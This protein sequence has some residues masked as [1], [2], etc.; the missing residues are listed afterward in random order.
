MAA[1][2]FASLVGVSRH[3]LYLWKK[4]F[5]EQGPA[6]LM[7]QPRGAK[8]GSRVP[9]LT[10]RAILL[11]KEAHPD[12]G[13]QRISDMLL[14]GP[15]LPVCASAV[16]K[17]LH[18]AGYQFE[19][20]ATRPHPDK[21]RFFERA[22]PNQLWQTD[23]FTFVLKRQNRRV[24]LVAFMDDH[25]RFITCFGL[26]G[27]ASTA[28]VIE[29]LR[30]EIASHGTPEEVLTDNGPQYVTWRGKSQFAKEVEK[31]GIR[32]IVAAPR[33][34]RTLGKIERFW[35][36]LWRECVE[37]AVFLDLD[38]AR[39]R[40]GLFIDGYNFSRPHSGIGGL[41]PADRYFRATPE[42]MRTLK[43]R[44]AANALELARNG[45][46]REPFYVTGQ[47]GGQAFSLHAEGERVFLLKE[48]GQRQE[49]DLGA[50]P[51]LSSA[52]EQLPTPVCPDGSLRGDVMGE[53]PLPG[54]AVWEAGEAEASP[55]SQKGAGS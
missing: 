54:Q 55:V 25:S 52:A 49:V 45:V 23:L 50:Q 35:G 40:I 41:V 31:R 18:E 27:S 15:A 4:L 48:G 37:G 42:V 47:V 51:T 22:S 33:K 9:E 6:G 19:E 34:P 13:C 29:V 46:P 10:R 8:P 21:P 39:T 20:V 26:Y 44:V 7:E 16:S 1:G 17:V 43:A 11:M 53:P 38:D 32:Q 3:T 24:Y 36:T 28:L 5:T 2:D 12:W 14:R 30:A